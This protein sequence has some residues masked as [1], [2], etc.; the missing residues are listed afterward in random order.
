MQLLPLTVAFTVSG[1][2]QKYLRQALGSWARV[3]GVQDVYL[4]FCIE[5][6]PSFP[7]AEFGGWVE[8]SFAHGRCTVNPERLGVMG[9]TRQAMDTA[10][11]TGAR[12]AVLA[13]EDVV[14]ASDALEYFRWAQEAYEADPGIMTVCAHVLASQS[15]LA[16]T[17]VRLPWFSPLVWGTWKARWTEFIEPGWG[18]VEGNP[19]GWD[20]R[21]RQRLAEAGLESLFPVRSRSLH[22]GETSTLFKPEL[23]AHM[24]PGTRSTCFWPDYPAAD[25]REV[26]VTPDLDMLV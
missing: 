18:G 7:A 10:F 5:P 12:F 13:E 4:L 8:R 3:R 22:I 6:D 9:N 19:Q 23:A 20:V 21:L 1:Q 2:R 15:A 16:S 11:R 24:Y 17:A 26:P 14:V 25:W